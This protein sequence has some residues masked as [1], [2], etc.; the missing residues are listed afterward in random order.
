MPTNICHV[1]QLPVATGLPASV[2]HAIKPERFAGKHEVRLAKGVGVE[3][4]GVNL[5][6]LDP[7]AMSALRH[8]HEAEDEL[9]YVLDGHVTV[10]DDD[11]E[12]VMGPGCIAGFPANQP[13]AHHVQNQSD[14]SA[15]LLV[16]GSRR[17]GRDVVHYP[18][19]D[20][21]PIRR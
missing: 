1:S 5:V 3:Q 2:T 7:G 18:D 4:F 17:P 20:L 14:R 8:W 21:G 19:D 10:I 9:V 16:V 12:R 11:G 13:N 15:T 6:T